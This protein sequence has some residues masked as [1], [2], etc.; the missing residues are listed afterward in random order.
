MA[1]TLLAS[2]VWL[3][4]PN[5]KAKLS[6][7]MRSEKELDKNRDQSQQ[8]LQ[9]TVKP[10]YDAQFSVKDRRESR[11]KFVGEVEA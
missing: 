7:V 8:R 4:D 10:R 2:I 1:E 5:T 6:K 9:C 11:N 3:R